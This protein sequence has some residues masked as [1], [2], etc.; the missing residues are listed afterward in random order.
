M[1]AELVRYGVPVRIVEKAAERTDKSKALVIWSRTLELLDRGIGAAPF[2]EAGFKAHAFNFFSGEQRIGRVDMDSVQGPYP[3]AL[4]LP[5]SETERLLEKRLQ[6]LG[7]PVEREVELISFTQTETD[8]E[9]IL[10]H[11]DGREEILSAAWLVGCDGAHSLVRHALGAT[12]A[13]E[14]LDSDWMLADV[15]MRGYPSPDTETSVYWHRDGVL[16]LFPISPGRY[17]VVANLPPSDAEHPAAPTLEQV[18]AVIDRRG[19]PGMVAFDPIW[20]T[21]FRI[22]DRKIADYRRGRI[23]L[24]GDAAHI[25]SPAG[26]QGMNTGMQDAFNLAWKLALVVHGT[27]NEELLDSYSQERSAVGDEVLK[28]TAR[29]TTLGTLRNPVAQGVRNL[30][31]HLL[32]GLTAV[33]HAIA[34][35]ITE[36][37]LGYPHSA[38]NGSRL[39]GGPAPGHRVVPAA[40]QTPVGSGATARFALFAERTSAVADL[41]RRF[42]GLLDP[43]IR[44]PLRQGALWL[45]R[46]DGYVAGAAEDAAVIAGYLERL[47]PTLVPDRAR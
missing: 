9:A 20:L 41:L 39:E 46:P 10:R 5:Q 33:Q 32:L 21:S 38:L 2:I 42:D 28:A 24:A 31:G 13:G 45:V 12:F 29:L 35:N 16:V 7:A 15:H 23:F 6:D 27:C 8:I 19:T 11:A 3:Y 14:T 44:P 1:A 18:Q 47:Q 30:L 17:R 26:G 4:M 37:S 34:D 40:D 22:N 43:A 25:H 36:V